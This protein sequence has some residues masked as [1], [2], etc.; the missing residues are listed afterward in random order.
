M[1]KSGTSFSGERGLLFLSVGEVNVKQKATASTQHFPFS[2][3]DTQDGTR[4]LEKR[5]GYAC[6]LTQTDSHVPAVW[7][8]GALLAPKL[9][10]GDSSL[11]IPAPK[12]A[13]LPDFEIFQ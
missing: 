4:A 2:Q 1:E 13:T 9:R 5:R 7:E 11:L 3:T 10:S 12:E 6:H 8:P